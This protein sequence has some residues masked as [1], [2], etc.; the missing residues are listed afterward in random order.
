[1]T[2]THLEYYS[3][4]QRE[5]QIGQLGTLYEEAFSQATNPGTGYDL[6]PPFHGLQRPVSS[7]NCGDFNCESDA[8][9]LR[10]LVQPFLSGA[11]SL[12]DAWS[13]AHSG[14]ANAFTVGL[15]GCA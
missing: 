1:M 5:T 4:A 7:V 15:N 9:E 14:V 12:V 10:R 3:R 6:D 8:E 2:T 11:P 13:V